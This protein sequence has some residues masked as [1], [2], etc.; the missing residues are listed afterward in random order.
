MI[1]RMHSESAKR[2]RRA[3][4]ESKRPISRKR[5][6]REWEDGVS[7]FYD[8]DELEF[9][10]SEYEVYYGFIISDYP[11]HDKE[12][13]YFKRATDA[14]SA[15]YAMATLSMQYEQD[16]IDEDEY[17]E[18]MDAVAE[19][20]VGARKKFRMFADGD[21]DYVDLGTRSYSGY[22][23]IVEVIGDAIQIWDWECWV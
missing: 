17:Q 22:D 14:D 5:F 21:T 16:E 19:K 6:M 15:Y 8:E 20:A 18:Q 2:R 10:L 12:V 4:L 7:D 23:E 1:K 11:M 9:D 3:R 13:I